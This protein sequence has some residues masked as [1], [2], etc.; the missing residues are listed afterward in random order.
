MT[1]TL[2]EKIV[3]ALC[4]VILIAT[5]LSPS[6]IVRATDRP[7]ANQYAPATAQIGLHL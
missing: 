7:I 3:D 1:R 4:A 2:T 5:L 6:F